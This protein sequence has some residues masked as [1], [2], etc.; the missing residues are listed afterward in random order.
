[1]LGIRENGLGFG[2]WVYGLE[3]MAE[4]VG[5]HGV[6]SEAMGTEFGYVS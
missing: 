4:G 3:L 2:V 6:P 5:V 1:M